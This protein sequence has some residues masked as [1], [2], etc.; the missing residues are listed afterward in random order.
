MRISGLQSERWVY[1]VAEK[2]VWVPQARSEVTEGGLLRGKAHKTAGGY[3]DHLPDTLYLSARYE[4]QV[5]G[6]KGYS[7]QRG[8]CAVHC[9]TID[10]R[11]GRERPDDYEDSEELKEMSEILWNSQWR[12]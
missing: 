5:Y 8:I 9:R 1:S 7:R 2:A 11:R 4:A 3:V 12:K 10:R 6:A